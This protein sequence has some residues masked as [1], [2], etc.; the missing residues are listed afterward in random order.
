[1]PQDAA[2]AMA[3][4]VKT[5]VLAIC[6]LV[7]VNSSCSSNTDANPLVRHAHMTLILKCVSPTS[8]VGT[9]VS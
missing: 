3:H 2:I 1:M 4:K 9:L 8:T 5:I 7:A 6:Q